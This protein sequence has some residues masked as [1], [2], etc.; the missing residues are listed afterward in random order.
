MHPLTRFIN[1]LKRIDFSLAVQREHMSQRRQVERYAVT[2]RQRKSWR[3]DDN[4]DDS[5]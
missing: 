5:P 1:F 4:L 2:A 3:P